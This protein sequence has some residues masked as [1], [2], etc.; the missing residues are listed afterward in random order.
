[1]GN[2]SE[3]LHELKAVLAEVTDLNRAALLLEWDQETY[4]PPG[5]VQSRAEQLSTLLRLS[6]ERFTSEKVARLLAELEDELAGHSFDSDEA[7]LVRVT[8]RDY[9]QSVKLPSELVAEIARAGSTARPVWERARHDEN[10]SLFAP[11]LEKNV[12]LN[13]RIADALGFEDRPYDALIDR[14]EP[15]MTTAQLEADEDVHVVCDLVSLDANERW[16]CAVDRSVKRFGV[17]TLERFGED[18]AQARVEVMPERQV[19]AD[20]VLPQAGLR[21]VDARRCAVPERRSVDLSG[22]ALVVHRVTR[23]V[24]Q[25]EEAFVEEVARDACRDTNVSRT[26]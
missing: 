22:D 5:G 9:D 20:E 26:E 25:A 3:K 15:G 16:I 24:E 14:N 4:M 13:R 12:E 21:L 18:G 7:S 10:F 11:Y 6:H 2:T 19:P 17:N 8:R 23:L 1:M